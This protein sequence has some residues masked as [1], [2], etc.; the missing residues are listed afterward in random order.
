MQT[1]ERETVIATLTERQSSGFH[2]DSRLLEQVKNDGSI[3]LLRL[4]DERSFLSLI[5]QE[6]NATRLLTPSGG[7]RTLFDV[8]TRFI[9]NGYTFGGLS[10][11]MGIARDQHQPEW[12]HN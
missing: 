11:D 10:K 2:V 6:I 5:W 4:A 3:Y 12:F 8:A 7:S 1:I 9:K